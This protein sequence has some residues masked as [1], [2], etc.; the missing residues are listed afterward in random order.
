MKLIKKVFETLF[1]MIFSLLIL[2]AIVAGIIYGISTIGSKK[3]KISS[4]NAIGVIKLTGIIRDSSNL[5]KNL[6]N[7]VNNKKIKAVIIKINS[8]GGAV[9]PSQEI[10]REIMRLK[11]K[12]KIFAYIQSLGASGAYYVASATD[13]IFANPGSIVGSIGVIM[14]FTNI[15]GLL[16]KIG[17]KGITIKSGKFKDVGNPT[18]EMTDEEKQYLKGLIMNVYTQFLDDVSKAR[19]IPIEKLKK[20]ADGRVFTGEEGLKL[21]LVDKLGNFDDVIDYVKKVCNIKGKPE[22]VYPEEKRPIYKQ[23]VEGISNYIESISEMKI[24]YK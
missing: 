20:I 6:K 23:I 1:S 2:F 12:K 14:E 16:Q 22:I 18:R 3:V 9:V 11:K 15:E 5:I 13:K 19:H 24:Y 21:G 8:P 4:D 7:F 17:I 10:Y